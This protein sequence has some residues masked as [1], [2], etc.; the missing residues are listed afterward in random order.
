M[1]LKSVRAWVAL[2]QS[3]RAIEAVGRFWAR[4]LKL[5][6]TDVLII[7][8]MGR[9]EETPTTLGH[10]TGRW[11]QQVH[12]SLLRLEE[13]GL[14]EPGTLSRRGKVESW[15]L[16]ESGLLR[17]ECLERRMAVW[18]EQL[19]KTVEVDVLISELRGTLRALV[20]RT[21]EGYLAGLYRPNEHGRDPN[22]EFLK[23]AERLRRD[24]VE[25]GSRRASAVAR[26]AKS[27]RLAQEAAVQDEEELKAR[28]MALFA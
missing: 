15:R 28:W 9:G 20:N 14:V 12:R 25:A 7:L 21:V 17:L 3:L 19:S 2:Q 1:N 4:E 24:D 27:R 11:R 16:S 23:E 26:K 8:L 6:P 13:Q 10:R 18:E 5:E 22:F